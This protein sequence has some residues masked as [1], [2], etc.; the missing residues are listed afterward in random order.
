MIYKIASIGLFS[1]V[2]ATSGLAQQTR[3]DSSTAAHQPDIRMAPDTDNTTAR[4]PPAET[5]VDPGATG[6]TANG[7]SGMPNSN[8]DSQGCNGA[9]TNSSGIQKGQPASNAPGANCQ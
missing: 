6:S 7:D 8:G 1:V 2:M 9:A 5:T 3:T 4:N